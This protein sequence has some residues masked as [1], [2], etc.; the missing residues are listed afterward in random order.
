M[1]GFL[2]PDRFTAPGHSAGGLMVLAGCGTAVG[3]AVALVV[4]TSCAATDRTVV[5]PPA[6]EG[7]TFVGNAACTECHTNIVRV[8]R[9]S[10]HGRYYKDEL[11]W[12][13]VAGCESC[14]GPGSRHVAA[15]GGRGR[16]IL[17][18]AKDPTSCL[19]CHLET[20][21]ELHLPSRHPVLE[22]RVSCTGCHDPHGMDILKPARGLAMARRNDPCSAC[23]RDQTRPFVFVHDAMR[24]GCTTCHA[25]HGSINSKLLL[26]RDSNLCLK[27][28]SQAQA[29][30][31]QIVIGKVDHT[32]YLKQG[33]CYSAG[34]HTAVHGSNV[35]PK[36]RY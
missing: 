26:V 25:A 1:G 28:H 2:Q 16:F 35:S 31:G 19:A 8:F 17:N 9:G 11:K 33:A 3:L 4:L 34:C 24:E 5:A 36:L 27:C 32:E 29:V 10:P 12:A 21:A 6:I 14:H 7:A 22:G 23:H 30:S 13:A 20:E 18:P 15:G